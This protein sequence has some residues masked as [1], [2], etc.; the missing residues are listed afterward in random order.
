MALRERLLKIVMKF[1]D[2]LRYEIADESLVDFFYDCW[3]L[4]RLILRKLQMIWRT[5]RA[6]NSHEV[7]WLEILKTRRQAD[8]IR[9]QTYHQRHSLTKTEKKK[10]FVFVKEE[11]E[12]REKEIKE[13]LTY[14]LDKHIDTIWKYRFPTEKILSI[15]YPEYLQKS[16]V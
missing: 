11:V 8:K 13:Y 12:I 15:I 1:R 7:K 9:A 10:R 3:D 5:V 14:L 2:E 4:F 16:L 6:P